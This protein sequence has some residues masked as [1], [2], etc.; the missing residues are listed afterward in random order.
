MALGWF[1]LGAGVSLT[2][3]APWNL[4]GAAVA[5]VLGVA[6]AWVAAGLGV[7]VDGD[8]LRVGR[9][10]RVPWDDVTAIA[11]RPGPF[12]IPVVSVRRGRALVDLPLEGLAA[13]AGLARRFAQRVADAGELGPVAVRAAEAHGRARRALQGQS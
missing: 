13:P 4:A 6:T 8:G 9:A 5:V 7:R 3:V 10:P 1:A 11:L 12:V 2:V